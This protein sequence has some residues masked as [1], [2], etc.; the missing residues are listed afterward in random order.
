[1]AKVL[2]LPLSAWEDCCSM[3]LRSSGCLLS[4]PLMQRERC[5]K[6]E[7]SSFAMGLE[8]ETG[9]AHLLK[10]SL[11]QILYSGSP[12]A[13][14]LDSDQ[15]DSRIWWEHQ[16]HQLSVL[17]SG[18]FLGVVLS[19]MVEEGW[20]RW[21]YFG[22]SVHQGLDVPCHFPPPLAPA[23]SLTRP[24][25]LHE[26][27]STSCWSLFQLSAWDF[28]LSST[29]PASVSEHLPFPT[30]SHHFSVFRSLPSQE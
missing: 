2:W 24:K 11:L 7:W 6:L 15:E 16:S 8:K 27:C 13:V 29:L 26:F 25:S 12:F 19:W 22:L 1:M 14:H 23:E 3:G 9:I 30:H 21:M 4:F 10:P 20:S 18:V 17:G 5:L 28:Q